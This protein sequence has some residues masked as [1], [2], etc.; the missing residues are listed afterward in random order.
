MATEKLTNNAQTTLSA[1]L[2][3]VS[4]PVSVVV[5]DPSKFPP[6]GTFRI[7]IDSELLLVTSVAGSTFTASRSVETTAIASHL[8]GASVTHVITAASFTRLTALT[9]TAANRPSA[10]VEGR[11]FMPSDGG[12]IFR[13]TGS[14]WNCWVHG[15]GPMEPP[16]S[17]FSNWVNQGSATFSAAS[18]VGLLEYAG[19]SAGSESLACRVDALPG[20]TWTM[21]LVCAHSHVPGTNGVNFGIILRAS[22]T[23]RLW[24]HS[25]QSNDA[26]LHGY[27][28]S[29]PTTYTGTDTHNATMRAFGVPLHMLRL[30]CDGTNVYFEYSYDFRN[31]YTYKS[32]DL[33]ASYLAAADQVGFY[34]NKNNG[35][36]SGQAGGLTVYHAKL[37]V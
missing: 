18:G 19:A 37:T 4:D 29:D 36:I 33:A 12:P 15:L 34:Y 35:S 11:L 31:W 22:G 30:R 5:A 25:Y 16:V 13:D 7:I 23:G 28:W 3:A 9:D 6:A 8:A 14:A 1:P 21:T 24:G 17:T 10:G 27:Q 2:D 26:S 32:Y 20:S